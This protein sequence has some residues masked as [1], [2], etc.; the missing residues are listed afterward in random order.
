MHENFRI[1]E[2]LCT[3]LCHDLTGPIGAVNNG[4]EF[5]NEEGFNMREEAVSLISNSAFSAIARLQFYRAAYGRI[6]DSGEACL[7][8]SKE[9]AVDYFK[10]SGITLNWPD[11]YTESADVSVSLK[12]ARL[13]YNLLIIASQSLM[14]G[15]TINVMIGSDESTQEKILYLSAKGSQVKEDPELSLVI[16]NDLELTKITPKNVQLYLTKEYARELNSVLEFH[17][18]GEQFEI[19]A[20]QKI[21]SNGV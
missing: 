9:I 2:L 3:R 13:L 12:M 11:I 7:S 18:D 4:A 15:G 6:K 16:E 20:K 1:A 8:Q 17:S 21:I 10:D 5:L 19:K 14:R